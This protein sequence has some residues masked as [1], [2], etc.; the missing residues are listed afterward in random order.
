MSA[1]SSRPATAADLA[2]LL[3]AAQVDPRTASVTLGGLADDSREVVA[4]DVFFGR[5]GSRARGRDFV[6]D[7]RA[8][9][10]VLVVAD[11]AIE[12]GGPALRVDDVAGALR[13]AAD[14]WFGRP[15]DALQLVGITGTKG[16]IAG[17]AVAVIRL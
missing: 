4:G 15:Q 12:D 9:G 2:R 17:E 6:A 1:P 13:T 3:G 11:E 5:P 14:A 8:R 16:F 10:A 7:A